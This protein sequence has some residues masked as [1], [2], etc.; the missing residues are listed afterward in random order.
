MSVH[1]NF[2]L[3]SMA[4]PPRLDPLDPEVAGKGSFLDAA[5]DAGF[6]KRLQRCR[7]RVR[8]A[9]F[10]AAFWKCPSSIAG[11][12][13]EEFESAFADLVANG[14]NLFRSSQPA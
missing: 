7:L 10:H 2:D 5:V 11:F 12:H 8:Q 14:R 13:Q 1:H 4:I 9:R 6:F 3:G